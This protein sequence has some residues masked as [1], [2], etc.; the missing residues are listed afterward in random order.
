[1][2]TEEDRDQPGPPP[3]SRASSVLLAV[4]E[5]P[6][7]GRQTTICAFCREC[8]VVVREREQNLVHFVGS[9]GTSLRMREGV[10]LDLRGG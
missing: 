4:P 3:S 6:L 10:R 2:R 8:S 1:M 9:G 7:L 5:S